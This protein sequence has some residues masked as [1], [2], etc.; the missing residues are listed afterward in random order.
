MEEKLTMD[1]KISA[2]ECDSTGRLGMWE[3]FLLYMNAACEHADMLGCGLDD[4]R[5]NGL[6]WVAVRNMIR[7]IRRPAMGEEVTLA[8]WPLVPGRASAE[9]DYALMD[10]EGSIISLGKTEWSVVDR[11]RGRIIS[12][13]KIFPDGV[14]FSS[15]AVELPAFTR[16]RFDPAS[17]TSLGS[18]RVRSTDCDVGGHMN[19]TAYVRMMCSALSTDWWKDL[20]ADLMEAY[21]VSQMYEDD[22][23]ELFLMQEDDRV[24]FRADSVEG[25]TVF[26]MSVSRKADKK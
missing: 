10:K 14:E 9:R 17:F 6:L 22:E 12:P 7:Y 13:A 4:M 23:M 1:L 2:G 8:T 24:I 25:K 3:T 16:F 5:K 18:Y 19:N 21:Y 26:W 11:E 15:D 20:G